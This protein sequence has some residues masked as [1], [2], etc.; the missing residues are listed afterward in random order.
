MID[1]DYGAGRPVRLHR[2][3]ETEGARTRRQ[4]GRVEMADDPLSLRDLSRID[5]SGLGWAGHKPAKPRKQQPQRF[6]RLHSDIPLPSFRKAS[7]S[8]DRGSTVWITAPEIP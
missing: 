7:W 3:F 2:M 1:R 5:R 6:S 4:V 8:F